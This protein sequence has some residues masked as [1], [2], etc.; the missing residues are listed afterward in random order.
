V[1]GQID[2]MINR[3]P[4]DNAIK[5]IEAGQH[6]GLSAEERERSRVARRDPRE[7]SFETVGTALT[8]RQLTQSRGN[9][10]PHSPRE[11]MVPP[12]A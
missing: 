9:G 7:P 10:R 5:M 1:A 11:P 8:P 6:R 3:L 4:H 2:A 12:R